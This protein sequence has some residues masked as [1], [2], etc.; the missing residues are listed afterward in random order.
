MLYGILETSKKYHHRYSLSGFIF[1][2]RFSLKVIYRDN[3]YS[4]G[5]VLPVTFSQRSILIVLK[6]RSDFISRRTCFDDI[7]VGLQIKF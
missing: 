7:I 6:A 1:A 3:Y 4:R 2:L 5:R